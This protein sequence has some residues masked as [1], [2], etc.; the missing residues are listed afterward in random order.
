MRTLP[1]SLLLLLLLVSITGCLG[2][3]GG[4]SPT[5][6]IQETPTIPATQTPAATP[7]PPAPVGVLLSGPG[8][9]P[10]LLNVLTP[11]ITDFIK[12]EG[13]RFQTLQTMQPADF[14]R[15]DFQ[16]IVVMAPYPDLAALASQAPDTRFLAVGF[17]E[18][19][20]A[21]N[22]SVI[23]PGQDNYG[24]Q[25]FIAGYLAAM[26]TPDW[27]VG[28][29]GQQEN[30]NAL[31]AREG[32]YVGA[33]YFCGLCNP[34]YAPTGVNYLYPKYLDLPQEASDL[35][36]SANV[37]LLLDRAVKTFYIAPGAGDPLIYEQLVSE[38]ANIIG[39]GAD[40][41]EEYRDS[42]VVSLE[43]DLVEAF[44]E[45]WPDFLAGQSGKEYTP[46]LLFNDV[47]PDL[48]SEGKLLALQSIYEEASSGRIKTT[49]D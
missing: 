13:L 34:K 46:P 12:A 32:F 17:S 39:S 3:I 15:D 23:R 7:S 49:R 10:A 6:E 21:E 31:A 14:E 24:I 37:K 19:E 40:F 33:K 30:P 42:W 44:Q 27:R 36:I 28:A 18:L 45:V 29:I 16:L 26:I 4:G 9:D 47:N 35:E 8:A 38:G 25:G 48:L 20:P 22:L 41:R 43:F 11:M 2:G 1:R 5:P